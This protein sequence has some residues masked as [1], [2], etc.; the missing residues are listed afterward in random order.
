M[1]VTSGGDI[2]AA[3]GMESRIKANAAIQNPSLKAAKPPS[4]QNFIYIILA[5]LFK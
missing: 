4:F 2:A 3:D 5:G 1:K